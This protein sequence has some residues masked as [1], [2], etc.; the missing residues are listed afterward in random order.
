MS[1]QD[2]DGFETE[3]VAA[4]GFESDSVD[5][6]DVSLAHAIDVVM[7]NAIRGQWDFVKLE[8][9]AVS[10]GGEDLDGDPSVGTGIAQAASRQLQIVQFWNGQV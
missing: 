7:I 6:A 1:A 3:L 10:F 2:F 8:T 9:F 4:S 5:G